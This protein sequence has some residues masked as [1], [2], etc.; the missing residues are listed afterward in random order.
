MSGQRPSTHPP[1][2]SFPYQATSSYESPS[3]SS[4]LSP[5]SPSSGHRG[6]ETLGSQLIGRSDADGRPQLPQPLQVN[7]LSDGQLRYGPE[8]E[9]MIGNRVHPDPF[10]LSGRMMPASPSVQHTLGGGPIQGHKRAYRQRRKDP[11]C[12]ACRERKV[13]VSSAVA[14][15]IRQVAETRTA[16]RCHGHIKLF[17]MFKSKCEVPIHQGN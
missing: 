8:Y 7:T 6:I 4:M 15:A 13:K 2:P 17:G 10:Q 1:P 11:S 3:A 9:Q 12:D 16:V 5:Q 14:S